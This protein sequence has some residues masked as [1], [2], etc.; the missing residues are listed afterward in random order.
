MSCSVFCSLKSIRKLGLESSISSQAAGR[1]ASVNP[2]RNPGQVWARRPPGLSRAMEMKAGTPLLCLWSLCVPFC[3]KK[4]K[5]FGGHKRPLGG[6]QANGGA[7]GVRQGRE[8][9]Q[10]GAAACGAVPAQCQL[11][12]GRAA[13]PTQSQEAPRKPLGLTPASNGDGQKIVFC[14]D[15]RCLY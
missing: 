11:P 4:K 9:R 1:E 5:P 14:K 12:L 6:S 10:E 13:W 8:Q 7:E 3:W 15:E 2:L